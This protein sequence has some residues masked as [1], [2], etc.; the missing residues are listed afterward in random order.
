MSDA[1]VPALAPLAAFFL[2]S[3]AN[4]C[5][6]LFFSFRLTLSGTVS[7]AEK[8]NV[9]LSSICDGRRLTAAAPS[10]LASTMSVSTISALPPFCP[11]PPFFPRGA[12]ASAFPRLLKTLSVSGVALAAPGGRL[13]L[14]GT[15]SVSM[16]SLSSLK[17]P[18]STMRSASSRTRKLSR[19]RSTKCS[20]PCWCM[21]SH[22]RP[23]VATTTSGRRLSSRSCFWTLIPPTTG[24]TS[25]SVCFATAL[26]MSHTC[27][28]SSRV[29]ARISARSARRF[30][31]SFIPASAPAQPL[32]SRTNANGSSPSASPFSSP[33]FS[34]PSFSSPPFPSPP[35]ASP[36]SIGSASSDSDSDSSA[37]SSRCARILCRI[38]SPNA[39]VLPLPVSAAPMTSHLPLIAGLRH[40]FWIGVGSVNPR[41]CNARRSLGWRSNWSQLE[42]SAP[43]SRSTPSTT[44]PIPDVG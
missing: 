10:P 38:G 3:P 11:L 32:S 18:R 41:S 21:S 43:S 34:S 20:W 13:I 17:C 37:S 29:G 26:S 8:T 25:T 30:R 31:S 6:C 19:P 14:G 27:M 1:S 33:S 2:S 5:A 12:S 9:C 40:S 24:T 39:S 44:A 23:G 22:S 4:A 16:M 7:V 35:F 42:T 15:G 28:A 36:R